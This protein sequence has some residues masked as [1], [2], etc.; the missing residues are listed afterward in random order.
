[1]SKEHAMKREWE[2]GT[3]KERANS[4]NVSF[5]YAFPATTTLDTIVAHRLSRMTAA[6]SEK[7]KG[8]RESDSEATGSWPSAWHRSAPRSQN[9]QH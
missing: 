7:A 4:E 9:V 1:M 8:E 6:S 2:R 5:Q 3:G